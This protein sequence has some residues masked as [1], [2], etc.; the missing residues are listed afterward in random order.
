MQGLQEK[1]FPI[2][3]IDD[4][5]RPERMQYGLTGRQDRVKSRWQTDGIKAIPE[6]TSAHIDKNTA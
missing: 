2:V 4:S 3:L 6:G 5:S 1:A